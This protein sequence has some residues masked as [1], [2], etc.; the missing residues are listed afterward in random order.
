MPRAL[1][2]FRTP[3]G[4]YDA[5]V[6]APSQKLRSR[7][8]EPRRTCSHQG[9]ACVIEDPALQAEALAHPALEGLS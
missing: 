9:D 4:F 8:G 3:V 5:I 6:A 7:P 2:V 1:T